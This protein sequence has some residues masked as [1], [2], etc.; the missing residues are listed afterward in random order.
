MVIYSIHQPGMR[1]LKMFDKALMLDKGG[2]MAF[3]GTPQGMLEYFW[4]VYQT[5]TGQG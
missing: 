1:L 2:K 5:E 4:R 3:Y